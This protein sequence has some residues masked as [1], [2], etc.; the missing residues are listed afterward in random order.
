MRILHVIASLATRYGGPSVACPALC[1][2]LAR[3][4]HQVAIYT[5]NVDGDRLAPVPLD[6][7]VFDH[8]VEIRFFPGWTHPLEYKFSP[9]LGRVLARRIPTYDLVH[10]YSLYIFS[11]TVA[12]H[13]CRRFRVPY[14]LHPHGSL[15]PFLLRRH[16]IRK[17]LYSALFEHHNFQ[18]AAAI[19]FNSSEEARLAAPWMDTVLSRT[20]KIPPACEIVPVGLEEECF[21][22]VSA[23]ARR[24]FLARH[25]ELRDKRI[26][27]FFGRLS[28]KK[29]LDLL[30]RAFIELAPSSGRTHLLVVGPDTEGYGE[31][32]RHWLGAGR[33]LERATFTG[34]LEGQDRN[35][36]LQLAD[37]FVLPSYSENFGQS[38]AEAM[39]S[40]VPVIISNKVNIW[41][42]IQRTGAGLVV[43]CDAHT[44]AA[45]LHALLDEPLRAREMGE[46]GRCWAAETLPWRIVGL[47][48]AGAYQ[49]ILN[50]SLEEQPAG[51]PAAQEG[52]QRALRP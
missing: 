50:R 31:K 21:A 35:V 43:P 37:V 26:L 2:E 46:R 8:G 12:A 16:P 14:L 45:A 15:D 34:P 9:S 51:S 27:L 38:V 10:I 29:G 44:L 17:R 33:L 20:D 42:E 48:M 36:A 19:L 13:L 40:R 25:P 11:A 30:A 41:P 6:Q 23:E 32:L 28:F 5:T 52:P 39:A 49:R 22:P 47:Q 24:Q 18:H 4:G 7:P 1:R 3:Q